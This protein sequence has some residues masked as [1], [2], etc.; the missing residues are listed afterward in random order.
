MKYKKLLK[1]LSRCG[2]ISET[3]RDNVF[4]SRYYIGYR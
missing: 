2:K 4:D 3:L 1:I